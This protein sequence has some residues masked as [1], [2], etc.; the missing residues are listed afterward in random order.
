MKDRKYKVLI[1]EDDPLYSEPLKTYITQ[2]NDFTV[3]GV[4]GS[5]EEA[6]QYI[7]LGL[8]DIAIIDMQLEEGDGFLLLD[9][10]HK[11]REKLPVFPYILATTELVSDS[12]KLKLNSGIVEYTF[13]KKNKKYGP[14]LI[15]EHLRFMEDQFYCNKK[16]ETKGFESELDRKAII[17]QRVVAELDNYYIDPSN[18]AKEYLIKAIC[19]V[20]ELPKYEKPQFRKMFVEIAKDYGKDWS[21]L[22]SAIERL[23]KAA[24]RE[25]APVDLDRAYRNYT[26]IDR[27]IPTNSEFIV[28]TANKIREELLMI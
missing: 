4:T 20:V 6:F 9:R 12:A 14:E 23:I 8:P 26:S 10:I 3:M 25:T 28:Y 22:N 19:M 11:A 16:P 1:V 5:E 24:W 21:A 27:G 7:K 2:T 17:R 15:V 13:F 18:L